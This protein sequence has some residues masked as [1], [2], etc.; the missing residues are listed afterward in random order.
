[1]GA[2]IRMMAR[3]ARPLAV[4]ATIGTAGPVLSLNVLERRGRTVPDDNRIVAVGVLSKGDLTR[5]GP[6]VPRLYPVL[7]DAGFAGLLKAIDVVNDRRHEEE[8]G[9]ES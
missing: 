7:P 1:M 8:P 5:L 3:S 2:R 9:L 6:H 4:P